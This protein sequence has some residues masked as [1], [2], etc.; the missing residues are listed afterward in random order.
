MR[1][2]GTPLRNQRIVI[3]GAGAAGIGIADLI[4][5]VDD[6]EGSIDGGCDAPFLV[7]GSSGAAYRD[8]GD[9]PPD[10]QAAYARAA[11]ESSKREVR[12]NAIGLA[13]VV[14]QVRPTMLIGASGARTFHRADRSRNGAAYERPIIFPFVESALA[15]RSDAGGLDPGPMAAR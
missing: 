2:C 15:R 12:R 3:F 10:Y 5:D 7:R 4:R 13:E 1:I 11:E 14:R 9:R 6:P 8:M